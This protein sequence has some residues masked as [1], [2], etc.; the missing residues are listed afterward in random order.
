MAKLHGNPKATVIY[1]VLVFHF[2]KI[3]EFIY[4][5]NLKQNNLITYILHK[6]NG[7]L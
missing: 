5:R 7:I 4:L 1:A 6:I 3:S 2:D